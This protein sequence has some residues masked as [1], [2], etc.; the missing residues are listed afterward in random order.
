MTSA[1]L[2]APHDTAG[3][4]AGRVPSRPRVL[5]MPPLTTT[6]PREYVHRAALSEVF[7]TDWGYAGDDTWVVGAQ[8]P[9]A[10]SF[11]GPA[12][13]LHDP[14]LLVETIRQAGILLSHVAHG[15]PLE[16]SI[17]W[18]DMRYRLAPEALRTSATPAEIELHVR[19]ED[20]VRRGARLAGARQRYRVLRDGAELATA[21]LDFS[22]HSPAVYRRLRGAYCDLE[23]AY[24]RRLPPPEPL[25][26]PLV[27]RDR[28]ADVVLSPTGRPH[29]WQ[30]RVDTA[31]PVL[32][33][34]PVDH[35]PGMLLV[36]AARQAA[37]AT[38]GPGFVLPVEMECAF[39]RYG[40][41]D[42]PC[43]VRATP[44]GHDVAGRFRVDIAVEQYDQP[45]FSARIAARPAGR[46]AENSFSHSGRGSNGCPLPSN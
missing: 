41:L 4:R 26:P 1:A 24:A 32:F 30:L 5:D 12:G 7:L 22:C 39:E 36:E 29:L 37:Q 8:W 10:H 40:E 20:L 35:T 44:R 11:Y 6:V 43:W 19:D 46:S 14:V 27:A 18:Q 17:I 21:T 3:R 15:V 23:H 16:N 25:L 34:H 2:A 31:H 38:A 9:R 13:G 33:D 45:V 42:A 28:T